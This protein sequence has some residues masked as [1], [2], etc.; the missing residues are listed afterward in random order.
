MVK[1][2][3]F[4]PSL[5]QRKFQLPT[6]SAN[7]LIPGVYAAALSTGITLAP[8][9]SVSAQETAQPIFEEVVVTARKREERLEDIPTAITALGEGALEKRGITELNQVEKFVPNIT[10]TNFGQGNTGHAAIFI[11][12]IGLQDHIITTDPAVGIY[13]DGVYLGRNMGANMDLMNI[14]RVEVV[15]GPQG[16]LFGRNTLGGA[17]NVVTKKPSGDNSGKIDLKAGNMDRLNGNFFGDLSLTDNLFLS[18]SGGVKS[19]DGVGEAVLIDSPK[20]EI[21][22]IFQ[23]FGRVAMLWEVNDRFSLLAT[24]DLAESDQGVS[25]H[26]VVVFNP[27]NMFG[28]TQDQQPSNPDDTFSLNNDLLEVEDETKGYSLTAE[29]EINDALNVKAIFGA[30]EMWF[31]GGLDNEKVPATMIEFPERGEAEQTTAE[32]QLNGSADWGDWVVGAYYFNEDGSND[33]PHVFRGAPAAG[34]PLVIPTADFDGRLY[35]EQETTS[36]ALFGHMN[37]DL[38]ELWSLGV[39]LR[40][41][42]DEKDAVGFV[43]YFSYTPRPSDSWDEVTGDLSL[44]YR[45]NDDMNLFVSYARGYQAGGYPPR[46]FG[47]PDTFVAFDPTFADSV[48]FGFKGTLFETLQLHA[49]VFGVRYTDLA[50]QQNRLTPTGFLTL[51]QNAAESEATGIELEGLWRP[52]DAF[53]LQFALGYIDIEITD[54]DAGVQGIRSGDSPALTPD[55][56]V[57]VSPQYTFDLQNGN[58]ITARMDY[59]YRSDMFGQPVNTDLNRIDSLELINL[60]IA[61]EVPDSGW[62]VSLYGQNL[63][64]EV[65]ALGK[66]DLDPTVL[67]INNNDRREYGVRFTKDL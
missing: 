61:Y 36:K 4:A 35:I 51:T 52:T 66:L 8:A 14:E 62:R 64:D 24:A 18:V 11:R 67:I 22:E 63:T 49:S 9:Q 21:G 6:L 7:T 28:L 37:L 16:T 42:E 29:Y 40:Y 12:G 48:E 27:V 59:Y 13:L 50:V 2:L 46:P 44:S 41:T 55:T 1:T 33:S 23:T 15:R 5:R 56:T 34:E 26:E 65:Y 10:Q 19:R 3:W 58:T 39:G 53:S 60:N 32:I 57:S 25:P 38:S 17:I 31:E 30:R 43:H 47:G 20:A 54:V 45:L